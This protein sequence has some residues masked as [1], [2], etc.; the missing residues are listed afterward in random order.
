MTEQEILLQFDTDHDGIIS[1]LEISVLPTQKLNLSITEKQNLVNFLKT[2]T[3]ESIL[4][5]KRFKDP[6]KK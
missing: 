5:D 4:K 3:D 1:P 6:F 2:L